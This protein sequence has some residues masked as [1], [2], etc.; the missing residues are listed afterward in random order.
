MLQKKR[1]AV[2]K[3]W[4]LPYQRAYRRQKI[5]RKELCQKQHHQRA[6]QQW[7][8][9]NPDYFKG[10]YVRVKLWLAQHPGYLAEYRLLHPDYVDRNRLDQRR[11]RGIKTLNLVDIQDAL[12]QHIDELPDFLIQFSRGYAR[13]DGSL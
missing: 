9:Q 10:S 2:C 12:R 6:Q 11:R 8:R 1:C 7:L 4:F 5:C 13:T 3:E